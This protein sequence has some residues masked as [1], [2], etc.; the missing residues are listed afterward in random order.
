MECENEY[1]REDRLADMLE[2]RG[3]GLLECDERYLI[4]R[5]W[6]TLDEV[7]GFV[8]GLSEGVPES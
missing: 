6:L 3:Y 7:Q 2:D 1:A 5:N 8:D 4:Y